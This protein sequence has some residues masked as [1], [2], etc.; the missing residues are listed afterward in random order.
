MEKPWP[1]LASSPRIFL[2]LLGKRAGASAL[3]SAERVRA[4]FSVRIASMH[5]P[6]QGAE[7]GVLSLA[8][9]V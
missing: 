3:S 9:T 5:R 7:S 6:I 2:P 4:G 8:L 1:E